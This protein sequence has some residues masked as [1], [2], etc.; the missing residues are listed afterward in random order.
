MPQS[1]LVPAT[2]DDG[3]L[4]LVGGCDLFGCTEIETLIELLQ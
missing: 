2:T 1:P 3:Q 4:G